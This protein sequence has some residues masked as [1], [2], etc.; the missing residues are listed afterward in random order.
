MAAYITTNISS[1]DYSIA[2]NNYWE[3]VL[4]ITDGTSTYK[5]KGIPSTTDS[6]NVLVGVGKAVFGAGNSSSKVFSAV[7]KQSPPGSAATYSFY[8]GKVDPLSPGST[9]IQIQANPITNISN[10][11]FLECMV[12]LDLDNDSKIGPQNLSIVS[13][14][15]NSVSVSDVGDQVLAKDS[16]GNFYVLDKTTGTDQIHNINSVKVGSSWYDV[17]LAREQGG[18]FQTPNGFD[19]QDN[20]NS[21]K[22]IAVVKSDTA[23]PSDGYSPPN[24]G[25]SGT[26]AAYYVAIL[27]TNDWQ[28]KPQWEIKKINLTGEIESWGYISTEKI[29]KY[30]SF[31]GQD[32]NGDSTLGAAAPVAI[33]GDSSTDGVVS[34]RNSD[35]DIF[36]KVDNGDFKV[37]KSSMGSSSIENNSTTDTSTVV[38]ATDTDQPSGTYL[39]ALKKT[40]TNGISTTPTAT[41]SWD[42]LT[43]RT[44]DAYIAAMQASSSAGAA[45]TTGTGAAPTGPAATGAAMLSS[46]ITA[47]DLVMSN[48]NMSDWARGVSIG[49]YETKFG[50]DLNGDGTTGLNKANI[51]ALSTDTQGVRLERDSKDGALF[52]AS[53]TG[54]GRSL[55]AISGG[56]SLEYDNKNASW[57]NKREAIAVEAIRDG[58]STITGYKLALK[59]TEYNDNGPTM[60][61]GPAAMGGGGTAT[62]PKVT[63]DIYLLDDDGKILN[64]AYDSNTRMWK[65]DT[66]QMAPSISPYESFF[67]EDLNGDGKAGIDAAS[68]TMSALDK[69]GLKLGRDADKSLY[70]VNGTQVKAVGN[71]SW[72]EYASS[73]TNGNK[74]TNSNETK[75]VAVEAIRD[76]ANNITGYKL[77]LKQTNIYDGITTVNWDV[78]KLDA[79]AKVTY[80]YYDS[81]TQ[82]WK[83]DSVRG[84]KSI[85]PFEEFFG[86][87][88]N[89]DGR[90][91]VDV[92][93]LIKVS[94][95]TNG[96][97]LA[98]DKDNSLYLLDG[99]NAKAVSASWL[100]YS[101]SWGNGS[102]KKE[103]I[104]VEA[105]RNN[106][107]AITGYKMAL[108]QTD[109]YDGK[110]T[111]NWDVVT[112]TAEAKLENASGAA[113]AGGSSQTK[114]ISAFEDI[115]NQDLNGDGRVGIDTANLVKLTSDT[116]GLY[117]ARDA[118]KALYIVNGNSAKAVGNSSW[119]EYDNNWGSGSN[120]R[121]AIAVEAVRDGNGNITA[122]KLAMKQTNNW[123][124]TDNVTWDVLHLDGDAKVTYGAWS[125]ADNKWVDNSVYGVK[126][127]VAY[128][129]LFN[130][131]LN[132]DGKI[133]IDVA[134]LKIATTDTRGVRL[135]RD[136]DNALFIVDGA[137]AAATAKAV[138]N[139]SW[140][141]YN[142]S[143]GGGSNKMEAVA[144]EALRDGNNT[145]TGYK[146]ALKQT[147]DFNGNKDEN[148]QVL[149]L[150]AQGNVN[151]GGATGGT[152][153]TK[154]IRQVENLVQEDLNNDGNTGISTATLTSFT[155]A[156]LTTEDNVKLAK[157]SSDNALYIMDNTTAI[158]LMDS[159]G[160]TPELTY[161]RQWGGGS[162]TSEV[163]GVA[164]QAVGN[165]F[166]FRI[167]VKV[168]NT[169][170]TTSDV[171]WQIHTVSKDGVLDWSKVANARSPSRFESIFG[172]DLDGV[173]SVT[174]TAI[175]TDTGAVKLLKDEAG[176]LYIQDTGDTD[177][178]G[179]T[180]LVD[181]QGGTP[182]FDFDTGGLKSESYAIHKQA[183]NSYRLA[184]KKTSSN[185]SVKWEVYN[186]SAR[187][188]ATDE[189]AI[190][191]TKTSFLKDV[192]D[193][194]ALINQDINADG[195]LGRP[196]VTSDVAND[197]GVVKAALTS[198][199]QLYINNNSTKIA[200]VDTFGVGVILSKSESWD[201][202]ASNFVA[203]VV[204]AEKVDT[205]ANNV[206]T[207]TYKIAVR[208]TTTLKNQEPSVNWKIYTT[209]AAGVLNPRPVETKSIA[210]W[211]TLFNQDL[212]P[213]VG[214]SLGVD[215]ASLSVLA[216]D[217]DVALDGDGAV[218]V[219]NS[220]SLIQVTDGSEGAI[221]FESAETLPD[222]FSTS[223]VVGAQAQDNGDIL[224][225]IEYASQ[226]GDVT[227]KSWVVHTLGV[228]GAGASAYATIDWTKAV[229]TD[230]M[231]DYAALF[232]QTF[233]QDV[234]TLGS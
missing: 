81:T 142:N 59:R 72:L 73:W 82:S 86:D 48:M 194:E 116:T 76:N 85:A 139:A 203:E 36:I 91:G 66:I 213:D 1:S 108:K 3:T 146:L 115:F 26:A 150:D 99:N 215:Q 18:S 122:Y 163:M 147:N 157:D 61:A 186:I 161:T 105:V 114:S 189:A 45:G 196:A 131:D 12:G 19:Y 104:A 87:D 34:G 136:K 95:D 151:W 184:V 35:G 225:A 24:Q 223:K 178:N 37:I 216:G 65:D 141:E 207:R 211:E 135:A 179:M 173:T 89:E 31:F 155:E 152:L 62:A 94:T 112:L 52:I 174:P 164:K 205:T 23:P 10:P 77:A 49:D 227:D 232:G 182:S 110:T 219:R 132:D 180:Y 38:A 106:A 128:E 11:G 57:G 25:Q 4:S 176:V 90:V 167:A 177:N 171:S 75:A 93:S 129:T 74:N 208:E 233:T 33:T 109:V 103:A 9:D 168:T 123:N 133:G 51:K 16:G 217:S 187:D 156:R 101:N 193:V 55:L 191:R 137:G 212:T 138:G 27:K 60:S 6:S 153:W 120:K 134:T 165:D 97:L 44:K 79:D 8:S 121:E 226:V 70:I 68:L 144:V 67:G 166:Q 111:V 204:S 43:I 17:V 102:N 5:L 209:D 15:I 181:A 158:T 50:Q 113:M 228:Q 71:A 29:S 22:A 47:N 13:K 149:N 185:Q 7:Y 183:D 64:G 78:L 124:G 210:R 202:G 198:Q 222:G 20:K 14:T 231:T 220:G 148:W 159:F 195:T 39:L 21:S 100:E 41:V 160:S 32:L 170:G 188:S 172:Q 98:R 206:T 190:N 140:L 119:L 125:N 40:T 42:V 63:W 200:V 127:M 2:Q 54:E 30:E 234:A 80:G 88:L 224:L 169:Y 145:I 83:D 218:Y 214:T 154:K 117:L 197:D 92:A 229:V 46:D 96:I 84:Q 28:A 199:N 58:N 69:S 175:A 107:G 56:G 118:E 143:W 221:S 192:R 162:T 230:D 53:G 201:S 126:S 130:Q